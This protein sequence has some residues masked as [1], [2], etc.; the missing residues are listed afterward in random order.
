MRK[1]R[2]RQAEPQA[3]RAPA[4]D[5]Q[6]EQ[7]STSEPGVNTGT[8]RTGP[9]ARAERE[10]GAMKAPARDAHKATRRAETR[11]VNSGW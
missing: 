3:C 9:R 1:T 2:S 6:C 4:G 10:T 11:I 7:S 8:Q 5:E